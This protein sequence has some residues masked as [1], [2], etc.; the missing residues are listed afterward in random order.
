MWIEVT[1]FFP[2]SDEDIQNKR[3]DTTRSPY[4]NLLTDGTLIDVGG[5]LLL[6]QSPLSM[7]RS[8]HKVYACI[9]ENIFCILNI[10]NCCYMPLV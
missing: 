7:A 8:L 4:G 6:F 10:N 1:S 9:H 3:G 2:D 5:I